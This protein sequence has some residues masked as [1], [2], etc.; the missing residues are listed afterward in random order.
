[1]ARSREGVVTV[2]PSEFQSP[3]S[4][5]Q[6][7]PAV[8]L[9][10]EPLFLALLV[11]LAAACMLGGWY[12]GRR[13]S[14]DRQAED[15]PAAIHKAILKATEAAL[16]SGSNDIH[17]RAETLRDRIRELLGPV[18][19]LSKGV[20]G[21]F[22][23]LETALAGKRKPPAPPP[24]TPP[25]QPTPA[26][27]AA[28]GSAPPA[29]RPC[30]CGA[31]GDPTTCRCGAGPIANPVAVNQVTVIGLPLAGPP[32][33]APPTPPIPGPA[34]APVPPPPMSREEQI[35]ALSR[36]VRAFHDHWSN[37]AARIAELETAREALSRHP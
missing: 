14:P 9:G 6:V 27:P 32:A 22:D 12:L 31:A 17:G 34:A 28:T 7:P 13:Q 15:A 21:P 11:A 16:S 20:S 30:I 37:K 26:L 25:A 1:M 36:A 29:S 23:A 4:Y 2:Y 35:D 18:L 19:T 10:V 8:F 3:E 5:A 24:G 33:S